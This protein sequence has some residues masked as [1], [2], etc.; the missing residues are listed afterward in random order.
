[1]LYNALYLPRAHRKGCW[2]P[3]QARAHFGVTAGK[4]R[5]HAANERRQQPVGKRRQHTLWLVFRKSRFRPAG[6]A[7]SSTPAAPQRKPLRSPRPA[8]PEA[9]D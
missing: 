7:P 8:R 9:C 2:A 1:M 3:P 5:R 4:R 6:R